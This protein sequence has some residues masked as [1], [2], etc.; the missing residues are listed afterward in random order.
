MQR[1]LIIHP[2]EITLVAEL[3]IGS[4]AVVHRGLCRGIEVA[5]KVFKNQALEEGSP[6]YREAEM[7]WYVSRDLS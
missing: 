3:G 7:L 6:W 2:S 4:Y 5:V 1:S